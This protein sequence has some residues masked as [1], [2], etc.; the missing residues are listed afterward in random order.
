MKNIF[1]KSDLR[2]NLLVSL[3][4][5]GT[6]ILSLPVLFLLH[7]PSVVK[8]YSTD[9]KIALAR[10]KVSEIPILKL[11]LAKKTAALAEQKNYS[12]RLE[13]HIGLRVSLNTL[14][15]QISDLFKKH[16]LDIL[17]ITPS[18]PVSYIPFQDN[19]KDKSKQSP[20]RKN[21]QAQT[22]DQIPDPLLTPSAVKQ[23]IDYEV[24]G[25]YYNLLGLIKDLESLDTLVKFHDYT[26]NN[27]TIKT[28]TK[29]NQLNQLPPIKLSGK[30]TVYARSL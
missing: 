6:C 8:I 17:E 14:Y 23:T 21:N 12:T 1:A 24:E 19:A 27:Q 10:D 13:N 16:N 30:I 2:V 7:I 3:P 15:A 9:R 5:L 26:L 20:P 22:G 18:S 28:K 25:S 11:R 4:L 29:G